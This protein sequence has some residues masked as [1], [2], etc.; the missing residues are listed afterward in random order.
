LDIAPR[1]VWAKEAQEAVSN[2]P[3]ITPARVGAIWDL[4][5]MEG[6][7]DATILRFASAQ[8]A[9][10]EHLSEIRTPTLIL[11]GEE[12]RLVPVEAAHEFHHAIRNSK[13]VIYSGAGHLPQEEVPGESAADVRAFLA[14]P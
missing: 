1:W 6:T 8:S 14:H 3:V 13:L 12:D 5:H 10:K 11:W 4:N 7:R 9:V 2:K